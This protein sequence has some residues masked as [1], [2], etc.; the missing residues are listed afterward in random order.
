MGV[1]FGYAL[2]VAPMPVELIGFLAPG[3]VIDVLFG[4]A[5]WRFL[6]YART[7]RPQAAGMVG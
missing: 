3:M 4:L 5:F 1:V 2:V 7:G 6:V